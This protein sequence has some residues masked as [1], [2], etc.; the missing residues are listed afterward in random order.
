VLEA[1]GAA[2]K[3]FSNERLRHGAYDWQLV[4]DDAQPGTFVEMFRLDS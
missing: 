2:T 3:E 1:F 4:D